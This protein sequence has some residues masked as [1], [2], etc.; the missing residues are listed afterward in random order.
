MNLHFLLSI[1]ICKHEEFFI[2]KIKYCIEAM[3]LGLAHL[4]RLTIDVRLRS[5]AIVFKKRK[6]I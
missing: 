5:C 4:G 3:F 2:L 1:D 6:I